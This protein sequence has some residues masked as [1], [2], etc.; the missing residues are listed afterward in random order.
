MDDDRLADEID[1]RVRTAFAGDPAVERRIAGRALGASPADRASARR[2]AVRLTALAA[3]CAALAV[4]FWF[5]RRPHQP[6]PLT[7]WSITGRGSLVVIDSGDGRRWVVGQPAERAPQ[8]R[9]VI[10]VPQ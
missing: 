8:G 3:L 4:A 2:P 10:V 6:P 7:A 1:R 5:W 9:Y